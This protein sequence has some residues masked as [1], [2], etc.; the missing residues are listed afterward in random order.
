MIFKIGDKVKLSKEYYKD[1]YRSKIAYREYCSWIKDKLNNIFIIKYI[2]E[3]D[4]IQLYDCPFTFFEQ[5]LILINIPYKKIIK[6][7]IEEKINE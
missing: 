5:D 6:K 3:Y 2:L 4:R 7:I 1:T